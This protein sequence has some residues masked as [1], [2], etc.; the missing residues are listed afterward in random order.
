MEEIEDIGLE[1]KSESIQDIIGTNPSFIVRW[2]NTFMFII[3]VILISLCWI[4]K[5]PDT[6]ISQI[7][8]KTNINPKPVTAKL[9]G[10]LI[11]LLIKDGDIVKRGQHIAYIE[12][13]AT[14]EDIIDL[15]NNLQK[16]D[17]LIINGDWTAIKS[18][19]YLKF[20]VC[21]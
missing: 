1:S 5:Y 2:G 8:I 3:C 6:I 13:L 10:K 9:D 17:T 4:I 11:K 12:G 16:I 20:K 19:N 14:V 7:T 18:I 15:E 21:L